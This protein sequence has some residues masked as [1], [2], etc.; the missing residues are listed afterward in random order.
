M[1][2]RI[3]RVVAFLMILMTL[4]S[5]ISSL[6]VLPTG[7]QTA[8]VSL[9][10]NESATFTYN[11]TSFRNAKPEDSPTIPIQVADDGNYSIEFRH[12]GSIIDF[13]I[14]DST[15]H[16]LP[17]YANTEGEGSVNF[18]T[19]GTSYGISATVHLEA[20]KTYYV[21]GYYEPSKTAGSAV[22]GVIRQIDELNDTGV[23]S[24][25]VTAPNIDEANGYNTETP[26]GKGSVKDRAL[27]YKKA[28]DVDDALYA[29]SVRD[30]PKTNLT[31]SVEENTDFVQRVIAWLFIHGIAD[32]FRAIICGIFGDVTIDDLLF[33]RHADTRLTF[34]LKPETGATGDFYQSGEKNSF[35]EARR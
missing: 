32:P 6:A 5:F 24:S 9:S 33:N 14:I 31:E 27:K 26:L 21:V 2:N 34:Y 35:L 15:G 30:V 18:G 25:R 28:S 20:E 11:D 4:S 3:I 13:E 16:I 10:V 23:S 12:N 17:I 19:T 1:N 29:R 22:V 8:M 7:S